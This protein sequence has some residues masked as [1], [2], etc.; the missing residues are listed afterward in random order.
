MFA[1]DAGCLYFDAAPAGLLE[2]LERVGAVARPA[3]FVSGVVEAWR[4]VEAV[5]EGEVQARF[6]SSRAYLDFR[7]ALRRARRPGARI[8]AIGC[9]RGFA[10][11]NAAYAASVV[12]EVYTSGEIARV[13]R[14]DLTP[15][16]RSESRAQYD[17]VVTHS[18]A[19]FAYDVRPICRLIEDLVAPGGVYVMANEPNSR[20]WSNPDCVREMDAISAV[21]SRE[22]RRRKLLDPARYWA[23]IRRVAKPERSWCE[24]INGILRER[25]QLTADLTRK[26]IVRLIDPFVPDG[27]DGHCPIGQNGIA[28]SDLERGA[29]GGMRLDHVATS[30]YVGRSNPEPVPGR[31][32]AVDER[33]AAQYPL[34]GCAF[35]AIW[36]KA[37]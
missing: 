10:G 19:H 18:L 7:E 3:D 30:G 34:D 28:W 9:G 21:E 26:E 37:E 5:T 6:R 4:A 22:K 32:R 14:L 20:F 35:T 27:Y 12:G 23:R 15:D 11:R 2:T 8:L 25:F 17:L 29:L 16:L 1:A 24:R 31:W 13:D 33:L 36:R